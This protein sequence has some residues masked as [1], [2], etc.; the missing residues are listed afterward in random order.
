MNPSA[1]LAND[2][3]HDASIEIGNSACLVDHVGG[4]LHIGFRGSDDKTDWLGNVW[5]IPWKPAELD[6]WVHRGFWLYTKPLIDPLLNM[7]GSSPVRLTGHS[8]G[9]AAACI[10]AGVCVRH[11]IEVRSL[12]TFGAPR[13]GYQS[14]SDL[15][16]WMNGRRYVI[17]GDSVAEVPISWFAFPY[18]HDRPASVLPGMPGWS[19]HPMSGY[20]KRLAE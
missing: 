17:E 7:I 4:E 13:P 8:L 11:G 19:D 2:S 18:K 16:G 10:F 9:G 20:L 15:T 1:T 3:Y 14:L 5:A 6:A 12:T